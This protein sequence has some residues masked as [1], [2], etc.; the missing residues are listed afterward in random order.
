MDMEEMI[1]R[2]LE[3][4]EDMAVSANQEKMHVFGNAE[5]WAFK[6]M[7]EIAPKTA[8]CWLD[9]LEAVMWNNYLSKSEAEDITAG[10]VNQNGTKG[11]HWSYEA[12]RNEVEKSGGR[13]EEVPFYNCYALWATANM[14]YSDNAISASEFVPKEQMPRFFYNVAVECLKDVD[15]KNFVRGY[16]KV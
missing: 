12:F 15:R 9:K 11:P 5:K 2:Y 8:Q 6:K 10:L 1:K 16:F 3:L 7:T 13:M 4:Y 14:R